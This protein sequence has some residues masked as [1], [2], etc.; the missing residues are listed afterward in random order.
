MANTPLNDD[1]SLQLRVAVNN[2]YAYVRGQESV[3]SFLAVTFEDLAAQQIQRLSGKGTPTRPN[4]ID[5]IK[6]VEQ[7]IVNAAQKIKQLPP[8]AFLPPDESKD[9]NTS[10]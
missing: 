1:L 8:D 5:R 4:Y 10:P 2:A 3:Q 9:V 7:D 6:K